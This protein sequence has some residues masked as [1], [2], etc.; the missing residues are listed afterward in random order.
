MRPDWAYGALLALKV[1]VMRRETAAKS[2]RRCAPP[3][4]WSGLAFLAGLLAR[5]AS[6]RSPPDARNSG[7][8]A[9]LGLFGYGRGRHRCRLLFARLADRFPAPALSTWAL[10][11]CSVG[12]ATVGLV[13]TPVGLFGGAVLI[14]F[15][16]SFLTPAFYREMMATLPPSQ[17]G[18][19]AATFS[20]AVDLGLGR[21]DT[22][23]H[24]PGLAR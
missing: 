21:H 14:A 8:T 18:A 23:R 20:I 3:T 24:H 1:P 12:L 11:W 2:H 13:R 19:A 6:S 7:W 9:R 16:I 10:V 22:V 5:R 4:R 17:R 15:G